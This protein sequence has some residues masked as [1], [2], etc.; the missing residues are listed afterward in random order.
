MFSFVPVIYHFH[1]DRKK[2]FYFIIS[3]VIMVRFIL[4]D[5]LFFTSINHISADF[6]TDQSSF[7]AIDLTHFTK[8]IHLI[9]I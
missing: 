2:D 5:K 7:S 4:V 9:I 8:F 3:F 1:S 6:V